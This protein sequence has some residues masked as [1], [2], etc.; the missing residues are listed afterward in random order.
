MKVIAGVKD[1]GDKD[2][3]TER[4]LKEE[5][6]S[7]EAPVEK[8]YTSDRGSE[9]YKSADE[10]AKFVLRCCDNYSWKNLAFFVTDNKLEQMP[11]KQ[12]CMHKLKP[13]SWLS[14]SWGRFRIIQ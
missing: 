1:I 12:S 5:F 7:A 3:I 4:V 14:C 11:R 6:A 8:F 13:R 2:D 9:S 10:S